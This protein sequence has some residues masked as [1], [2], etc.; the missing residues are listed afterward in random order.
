M[1]NLKELRE[2][3]EMTQEQ[4]ADAC[5]VVRTTITMIE[6]GASKPSV[7]LAQRLGMVL[8]VN[9]TGFYE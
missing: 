9:W 1:Y 5:G 4:L 3:K 8:Q 7:P 2:S 6:T